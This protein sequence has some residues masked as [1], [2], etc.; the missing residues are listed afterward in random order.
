MIRY[1][2]LRRV[3]YLGRRRD[4]NSH[5][6]IT[7]YN[8]NTRYA[9]P[10][11]YTITYCGICNT[12]LLKIQNARAQ[13][14]V[15]IKLTKNSL[16]PV[17]QKS[18]CSIAEATDQA[19]FETIPIFHELPP[20]TP[21]LILDPPQKLQQNQQ[22]RRHAGGSEGCSAKNRQGYSTSVWAKGQ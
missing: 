15:T 4:S 5:H 9:L 10:A 2:P 18:G 14:C 19:P 16:C 22:L 11:G 1:P 3:F 7:R 13:N 21:N 8:A 6:S 17:N 12:E 20:S